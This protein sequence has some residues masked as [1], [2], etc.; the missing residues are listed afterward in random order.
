MKLIA[1][2]RAKI[3]GGRFEF[4]QHAVDQSITRGISVAEIRQAVAAGEVIEDY[5]E[6]KYGPSCLVFGTTEAGR[7]LH[8]Q[9]SYPSRPILKIITL[10][11][12]DPDLWIQFRQ[13]RR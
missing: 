7:P 11:E 13:R 2:I 1:E 4:S 12:P 3:A 5:P 6:D 8:V 9:C 10:Y